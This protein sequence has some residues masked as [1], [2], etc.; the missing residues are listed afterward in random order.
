M[1]DAGWVHGGESMDVQVSEELKR[2]Y[3]WY[4]VIWLTGVDYFSTLGY[5]PGIA[6]LAA[7]AL[8]P[9]ATAVLVLVTL[10]GALPLYS[11]GAGRS[12]VGLGSIALLEDFVAGWRGKILV[13]GLLGFAGTDVGVTM[14]PSAA[15][16]A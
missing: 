10:L 14:P 16:P 8:S 4:L 6:L 7:G 3:P 15:H 11:R 13:L 1:C 12:Y 9:V 5:Q 2:C